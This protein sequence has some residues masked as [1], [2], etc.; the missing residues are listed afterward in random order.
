MCAFLTDPAAWRPKDVEA[1]QF[2]RTRPSP[3]PTAPSD[4][5]KIPTAYPKDCYTGRFSDVDRKLRQAGRSFS[6][7]EG[8]EPDRTLKFAY[9]A[10]ADAICFRESKLQA[11]KSPHAE[12]YRRRPYS[13]EQLDR[14]HQNKFLG[15]TTLPQATPSQGSA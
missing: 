4:H 2:D 1:R 9:T 15:P 6:P 14:R 8:R 11:N 12:P 10:T 3:L 13:Y 7:R 5:E